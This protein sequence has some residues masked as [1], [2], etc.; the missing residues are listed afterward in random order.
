MAGEHHPRMPSTSILLS[1]FILVLRNLHRNAEVLRMSKNPGGQISQGKEAEEACNHQES[2]INLILEKEARASIWS[3]VGKKRAV[4]VLNMGKALWSSLPDID[5]KN[6][7]C[8]C[9][10]KWNPSQ[11]W[12]WRV[13]LLAWVEILR[14]EKE[15]KRLIW[16]GYNN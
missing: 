3:Q 1:R 10:S 8:L 9:Y 2:T 6:R 5:S 11:A 14:D 15:A 16:K 12:P 4:L 13:W 7:I